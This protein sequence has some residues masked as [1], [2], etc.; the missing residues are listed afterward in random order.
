MQCAGAIFMKT[1]AMSPAHWPRPRLTNNHVAN[2][3]IEMRFAHMKRIFKLD[4]L[5]LRGL[6]GAKD[7]VLLTA[8]AQNLRRLVKF[9]CR[10]PPSVAVPC[11]AWTLSAENTTQAD[12]RSSDPNLPSFATQSGEERTS[13]QGGRNVD[14][15]LTRPRP[16]GAI[17]NHWPSKVETRCG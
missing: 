2:A 11:A 3:K 5:R 13:G 10:P 4:R 9:L 6:R 14:P 16:R 15:D 17:G 8:T 7:E 12:K 1:L